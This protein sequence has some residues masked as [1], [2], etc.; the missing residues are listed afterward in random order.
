MA[1]KGENIFRRKDGR[2]EARYI[3]RCNLD[4]SNRYGYVYGRT[5]Q[6]VKGKR[7][8]ILQKIEEKEENCIMSEK[9]KAEFS[10]RLDD[11]LKFEKTAIKLSTYSYYISIINRHIRPLLGDLNLVDIDDKII[12][13]FISIKIDE[14]LKISTV[15]EITVILKQI[16]NF[17]NLNI[18]VKMPKAQKNKIDTLSKV[19]REKLEKYINKNINE[20]T[21]GILFSLY[22]GLR[23]GEVCALRWTDIDFDTNTLYIQRTIT[24]VRNVS[25]EDRDKTKLIMND[26]K[27]V[28]S[29]REIPLNHAFVK[30]LKKFKKGKKKEHFI[31]SSSNMYIDPRNYYNQYKKILKLAGI[32][33]Y[34]YHALRHTF[35]TNCIELGLDPKSLSEILGHSDIKITLSLYVHPSLD[36]KR[37]FVDKK[38]D[39][40]VSG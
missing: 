39:C 30:L 10:K 13:S 26:A 25:E 12:S 11:W 8:E 19:D 35:A 40:S 32:R 20:F 24:R 14:G 34:K 33:D 4:G 2:W 31:L 28:N 37:D 3:T 6:E 27:T 18:K 17:C 29:I 9:G 36:V 5:Y 7:T 38:L 21:I 23:I 1:R 15:R 22:C 16:L